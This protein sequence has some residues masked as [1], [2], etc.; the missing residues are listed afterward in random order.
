MVP[1]ITIT[2]KSLL[3]LFPKDS[4]INSL[5][6]L[7]YRSYAAQ[8]KICMD[9]HDID[10]AKAIINISNIRPDYAALSLYK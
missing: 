8:L 7:H 4:C 1:Q 5:Y 3:A 10:P 9:R 2:S 6:E